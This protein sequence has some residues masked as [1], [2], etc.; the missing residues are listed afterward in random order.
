MMCSPPFKSL[1]FLQSQC[2]FLIVTIQNHRCLCV[3]TPSECNKHSTGRTENNCCSRQHFNSL[4]HL[5][6]S[7]CKCFTHMLP[8]PNRNIIINSQ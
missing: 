7:N 1:Y 2:L 6:A 3:G 8:K 5:C 4:S